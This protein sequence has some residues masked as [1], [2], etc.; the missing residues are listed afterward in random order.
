MYI[1]IIG[2]LHLLLAIIIPLYGLLFKKSDY[3]KLYLFYEILLVISWTFYDGECVVSYYSKKYK[4]NNYVAGFDTLDLHDIHDIFGK[5]N[6]N[7][8]DMLIALSLILNVIS[9]YIVLSR[10]QYPNIISFMFP[11]IYATYVIF[12]RIKC[13][14]Y[15]FVHQIYKFISIILLIFMLNKEKIITTTYN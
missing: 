4:D 9:I 6:K 7:I 12:L 10:N 8:M 15:D 3:D 1:K 2:I 11:F 14:D 5:N 13:N